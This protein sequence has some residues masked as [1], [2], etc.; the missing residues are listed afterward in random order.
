MRG[1][2]AEGTVIR[3]PDGSTRRIEARVRGW[4]LVDEAGR[5]TGPITPDAHEL[6]R[7]VV[8]LASR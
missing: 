1:H 8:E 2:V 5:E 4:V 3:L 6:T 7:Q